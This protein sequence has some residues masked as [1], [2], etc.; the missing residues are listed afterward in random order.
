VENVSRISVLVVEDDPSWQWN[1]EEILGPEG[2]GHSV[3]IADSRDDGIAK[4]QQETFDVAIVDLKLPKESGGTDAAFEHGLAVIDY[5]SG[6]E[7]RPRVLI[8]T[9]YARLLPIDV[10]RVIEQAD[11]PVIPREREILLE[12]V[13]RL[14]ASRGV[15]EELWK[16]GGKLSRVAIDLNG[17]LKVTLE[18]T[19]VLTG[20][21][22]GHILFPVGDELR[23]FVGTGKEPEGYRVPVDKS[24]TGKAFLIRQPVNVPNI[25][26]EDLYYPIIGDGMK[27]ELAVPLLEDDKAVGVL[28]LESDKTEAFG[29]LRENIAKTIAEFIVATLRSEKR[30]RELEA[31]SR[32][33]GEVLDSAEVQR[34]ILEIGVEQL[35]A[36]TGALLLRD[37]DEL[38]V[39][40]S[41]PE[42]VADA[43]QVGRRYRLD[44][45]VSGFA[46]D[47]TRVVN[48]KDV[49]T[50][51]PYCDV[52]KPL[53]K[54]MRSELVAP[55]EV[56]GEVI[57]ALNFE[58]PRLAAFTQYD[59][60]LLTALAKQAAI[61]LEKTRLYKRLEEAKRRE[62]MAAIGELSGDLVHRMNSPLSAVRANI[63]LI[64]DACGDEL[65]ANKYLQEKLLEIHR[66]AD[67]AIDMVQEMKE[68]ARRIVLE[69]VDVHLLL[70]SAL[71]EIDLPTNVVL[72][73]KSG[74]HGSLP[75]VRASKQLAKVFRNLL[76]NA[77][78]AMP[79]GGKLT[80]DAHTADD[81]WVEVTVEDTGV[82]IPEEW[83]EEIFNILSVFAKKANRKGQGLGLWYSRAYV[84]ACGGEL[85]PP[86][87][88]VGKGTK[89]T[90]RFPILKQ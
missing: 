81:K 50:E 82:G 2:A 27:S 68:K 43:P 89:F 17:V 67:E 79:H 69:P 77:I 7:P 87:S 11:L 60:S 75:P 57:G 13:R 30:R 74:Q 83:R 29:E 62:K 70:K 9:G 26:D 33:L 53:G 35:G 42:G 65:A 23:I 39:E 47:E 5:I 48:V 16:V 86:V 44:D 4:L 56:G 71:A 66:I 34:S 31:T 46:V 90:V 32:L 88:E 84:E 54:D 85:P 45:C 36:R 55:L 6:L 12:S 3:T 1:Y 76:D 19:K 64:Q 10:S 59:E 22:I 78:D 80:L 37:G 63:Q 28:N 15:E 38:F 20:A 51:E 58:S 8:S 72:E 40:A 25:E 49:R 24:V 52:Y 73:D 14:A 61:A 41:H 21:Q 18:R